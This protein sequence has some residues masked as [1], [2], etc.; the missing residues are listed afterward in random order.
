[1]LGKSMSV[2]EYGRIYKQLVQQVWSLGICL[3]ENDALACFIL[4]VPEELGEEL[5]S[6]ISAFDDRTQFLMLDHLLA[7]SQEIQGRVNVPRTNKLFR[8]GCTPA[9]LGLPECL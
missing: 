8:G 6:R 2:V 7:R 9:S 1:M 3:S 5:Q 4:S